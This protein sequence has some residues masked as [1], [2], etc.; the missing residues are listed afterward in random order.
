MDPTTRF[1]GKTILVSGANT[2]LGLEAAIKFVQ[3]GALKVIIGVRSL[4]KGETAKST[5]ETRTGRHGVVEVWQ[6]DMDSYDSIKAF[7]SRASKDLERVDVAVLNAGI[8]PFKTEQSQYEWQS[9]IQVNTLSTVLLGLL[10]LPKLQSSGSVDSS[11]YLEFVGSG[12]YRFVK[13]TPEHRDAVNILESYNDPKEFNGIRYYHYSKLFLICCMRSLAK[14][15]GENGHVIISAVC[16]G[17]VKTDLARGLPQTF[18][19]KLGLGFFSIFQRSVEVGSRS[20]VSGVTLGRK[21]HGQFW[22]HDKIQE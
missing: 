19:T 15:Q 17:L 2:G 21:V 8:H 6:L 7:A 12:T 11:S 9:T 22:Q 20:Y 4:E 5:I 1:D 18:L 13:V 14:R 16:P 10:L 3:L